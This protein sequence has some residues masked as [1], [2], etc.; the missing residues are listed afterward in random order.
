MKRRD[1]IKCFVTR[2]KDKIHEIVFRS[3]RVVYWRNTECFPQFKCSQ[4]VLIVFHE[5]RGY[6][7]FVEW[8]MFL[9][10]LI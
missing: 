6:G 2:F 4:Q 5:S 7:V 1:L 10:F 3:S 9:E 8:G